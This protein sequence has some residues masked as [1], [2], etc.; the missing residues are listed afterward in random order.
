M[1]ILENLPAFGAVEG[2]LHPKLHFSRHWRIESWWSNR[3]TCIYNSLS[4][5]TNW[6]VDGVIFLS[7]TQWK[8]IKLADWNPLLKSIQ[9]VKDPSNGKAYYRRGLIS[10]SHGCFLV[11]VGKDFY[12]WLIGAYGWFSILGKH[13]WKSWHAFSSKAPNVTTSRLSQSYCF[14]PTSWIVSPVKAGNYPVTWFI[15]FHAQLA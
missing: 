8:G 3:Y 14:W 1:T 13:Q 9:S 4:L 7:K 10:L 12:L 6:L 15:F 11:Q 5:V 2:I